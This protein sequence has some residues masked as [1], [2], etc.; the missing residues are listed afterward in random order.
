M[1]YY[2]ALLLRALH[3]AKRPES[4]A[5]LADIMTA[6]AMEAGASARVVDGITPRKA[7]AL[8]RSLE[9]DGLAK[10]GSYAEDRKHRR[11]MPLWVL[12]PGAAEELMSALPSEVPPSLPPEPAGVPEMDELMIHF[13]RDSATLMVSFQRQIDALVAKYQ[14]DYRRLRGGNA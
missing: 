11:P 13:A 1:N 3:H 14:A 2:R 12:E 6:L 10:A 8:L 4:A 9:K 7:A 5:D